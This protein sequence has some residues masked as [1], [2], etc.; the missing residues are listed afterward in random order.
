MVSIFFWWKNRESTCINITFVTI[1]ENPFKHFPICIKKNY[2]GKNKI[3]KGFMEAIF[4]IFLLHWVS[5]SVIL[6][7]IMTTRLNGGGKSGHLKQTDR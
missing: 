4:I 6:T 3:Q 5:L 2:L 7:F 1:L